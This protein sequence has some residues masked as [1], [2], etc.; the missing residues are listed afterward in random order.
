MAEKHWLAIFSYRN[1]HIRLILVRRSRKQQIDLL[2]KAKEFDQK[3]EETQ[4][5][6]VADLELST[7]QR[8]N[9]QSKRI[10]VDFPAWVIEALDR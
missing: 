5:N 9:L 10:N 3:F 1:Q 4:E 2:M 6:I 7:T 8:V